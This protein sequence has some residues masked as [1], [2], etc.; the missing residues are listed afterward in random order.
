MGEGTIMVWVKIMTVVTVK[1]NHF[2]LL[3]EEGE[4]TADLY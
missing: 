4:Q 3:E 1:R 2:L